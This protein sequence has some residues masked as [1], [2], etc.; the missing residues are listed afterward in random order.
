[1]RLSNILN[2][3]LFRRLAYLDVFTSELQ[4]IPMCLWAGNTQLHQHFTNGPHFLNNQQLV[5]VYSKF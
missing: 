1:M 5:Y 2:I 3:C 4:G